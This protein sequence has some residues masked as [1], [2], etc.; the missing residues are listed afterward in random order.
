M[1]GTIKRQA[2]EALDGAMHTLS[3]DVIP[4]SSSSSSLTAAAAA[5]V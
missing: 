2:E 1:S 3:I 4:S 5:G